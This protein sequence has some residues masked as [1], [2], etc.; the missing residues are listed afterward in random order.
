MTHVPQFDFATALLSTEMPQ[1]AGLSDGQGGPAAKRF[2]VYRNNVA[3]SLSDALEAS[4]PVVRKLVGADFFRAMAG[5]ALRQNPP[6]SPLM[7]EFGAEFPAFLETFPPVATLPYLADVASIEN[8]MRRSYHAADATAFDAADLQSMTPDQFAQTCF[9][10][11]PATQILRSGFAAGSIWHA[12]QPNGPPQ[13]EQQPQDVIIARPEFDPWV[14]ILPQGAFEVLSPLDGTTPL[15]EALE[16]APEG[17]DFPT[18][19][20]LCLSYGVLTIIKGQ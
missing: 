4:F 20:T 14:H 10:L 1:P 18:T 8:A 3:V 12:N 17:F 2:N 5:V 16:Q 11:T 6:Q 13:T 19:L 9:T 7:A 15:A